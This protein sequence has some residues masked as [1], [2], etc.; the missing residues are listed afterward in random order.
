MITGFLSIPLFKFGLSAL[1]MVGEYVALVGEMAPSV[2]L[3]LIA[4][5]VFSERSG[6][7]ASD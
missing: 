6:A 5:Y 4:G 2:G 3:A 1:P 7:R